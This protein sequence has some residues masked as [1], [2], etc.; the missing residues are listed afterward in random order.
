MALVPLSGR[1]LRHCDAVRLPQPRHQHPPPSSARQ[2]GAS[3]ANRTFGCVGARGFESPI[4]ARNQQ[5]SGGVWGA[6]TTDGYVFFESK[7]IGQTSDFES[8]KGKL[9]RQNLML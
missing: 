4:C 9:I 5:S 8:G 6:R 2:Q 3:S 1:V 7:Y